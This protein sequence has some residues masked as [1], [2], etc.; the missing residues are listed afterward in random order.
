MTGRFGAAVQVRIVV[1]AIE[2]AAHDTPV[3]PKP[4]GE[5]HVSRAGPHPVVL[6]APRQRGRPTTVRMGGTGWIAAPGLGCLAFPSRAYQL[7]TGLTRHGGARSA[8]TA[9]EPAHAI[10]ADGSRR[11]L[12]VVRARVDRSPQGRRG[13]L[14]PPDEQQRE[15]NRT[16]RENNEGRREA[17]VRKQ[18]HLFHKGIMFRG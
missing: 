9:A 1:H 13:I 10:L 11:T 17:Q 15:Q 6:H 12:T 4:A 7:E 5:A 16:E 2:S 8:R 3:A 14:M 18:L